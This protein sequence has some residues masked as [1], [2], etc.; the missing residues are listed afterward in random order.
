MLA[1]RENLTEKTSEQDPA[2]EQVRCCQRLAR[3]LTLTKDMLA[4]AKREDWDEVGR[5]DADRKRDLE[6][7]FSEPVLRGESPV[8]AEAIA[9]LL[10]LNEELMSL[11]MQ[12]RDQVSG[13]SREASRN[14]SA[15][16]TYL[17]H[18]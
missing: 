3:A 14:R 15:L 16:N 4:C 9:A 12:A 11:V 10:H 13:Q 1:A 18:R 6:V 8:I 17:N 7:C 5:L 2:G